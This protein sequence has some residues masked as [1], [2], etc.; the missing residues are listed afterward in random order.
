M[1]KLET[2]GLKKMEINKIKKTGLYCRRQ[3]GCPLNVTFKM[4]ESSEEV[5]RQTKKLANRNPTKYI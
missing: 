3:L 4:E 5:L 1:D 2:K